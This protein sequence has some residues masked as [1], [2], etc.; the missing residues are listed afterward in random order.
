MNKLL[1]FILTS[2]AF[3]YPQSITLIGKTPDTICVGQRYYDP[4][5]TY[6]N[7][8]GLTLV[9]NITLVFKDDEMSLGYAPI[10]IVDTQCLVRIKYYLYDPLHKLLE[11]TAIRQIL[12]TAPATSIRMRPSPVQTPRPR[13]CRK[14]LVNGRLLKCEIKRRFPSNP[15]VRKPFR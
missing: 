14:F 1:I 7:T 2:L 13:D 11:A 9:A 10:F 3:A 8:M 4:G 6:D 15:V 12:V 5:V